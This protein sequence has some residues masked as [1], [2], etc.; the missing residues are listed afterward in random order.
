MIFELRRGWAGYSRGTDTITV[1]AD[2]LDEA[3]E[4]AETTQDYHRETV[5]D[6]TE[7]KEWKSN[8]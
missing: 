1:E 3:I 4:I 5:R 6:D 7:K 2:T 8:D